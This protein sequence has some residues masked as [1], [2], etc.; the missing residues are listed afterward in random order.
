[1]LQT[2]SILLVQQLQF[3]V[4][5]S[6]VSVFYLSFE[7]IRK[8]RRFNTVHNR[9]TVRITSPFGFVFGDYVHF[10]FKTACSLCV[11]DIVIQKR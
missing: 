11:I 6:I 10:S 7:D 9:L 1:M 2:G 3:E 4:I 5:L 8:M